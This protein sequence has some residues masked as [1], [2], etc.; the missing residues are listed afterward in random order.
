M[1][2]MTLLCFGCSADPLP[3]MPQLD[4]TDDG[5]ASDPWEVDSDLSVGNSDSWAGGETDE[6]SAGPTEVA[7]DTFDPGNCPW[8]CLELIGPKTCAQ[9]EKEGS[10]LN[11]NYTCG[12]D[13]YVCCQPPNAKGG[14]QRP[15]KDQPAMSCQT[16]C[17]EGLVQNNGYYC[18]NANLVCCEDPNGPAPTCVELGGTCIP[19]LFYECSDDETE[20]DLKCEGFGESC[21]LPPVCPW[22]CVSFDG[23][24]TCSQGKNPPVGV[25]RYDYSCSAK[26]E[27]CCQPY[28]ILDSDGGVP[29][30]ENC[31]QQGSLFSCE[32][33]CGTYE[34]QR[35]DFYCSAAGARCCEDIRKDC[36]SG[37][38]GTCDNTIFGG[39]PDDFEPNP[40]G[41]CPTGLFSEPTC[42]TRLSPYNKCAKEGGRC[43]EATGISD[44]MEI[45]T[46]CPLGYKPEVGTTCG[47]FRLCCKSIFGG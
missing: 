41:R 34:R 23:S 14:I 27:V 19:P 11:P 37:L 5:G 30:V 7:S 45:L 35:V 42:C 33:S 39:C 8:E 17:G 28:E 2:L 31:N 26:G 18:L 15:C 20:V 36:E 24:N 25:R 32:A 9:A 1:Y 10:F 40:G 43:V 44:P 47:D 21:C 13:G 4:A 3:L 38:G 12:N 22:G 46:L 29:N 16:S 6:D